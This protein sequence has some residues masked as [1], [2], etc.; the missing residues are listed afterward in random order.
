M[1]SIA[2][3]WVATKHPFTAAIVVAFLVVGAVAGVRWVW[4]RV[5][6]EWMRM[7]GRSREEWLAPVR[8]AIG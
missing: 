5:G 8:R 4:R 7:K 2:V 1:L 3:T 6:T